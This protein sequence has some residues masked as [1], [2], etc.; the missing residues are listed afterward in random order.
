MAVL[1][2]ALFPGISRADGDPA[3]DV[4]ATQPLFLPQDAGLA[5][6]QQEQLADLLREA[7]HGGFQIRV[8]LIASPAD[9]GSIPEL[10][11]QPA[12]YARYL[13]QE[14]ELV[15][16]GP[17][18]VVMPNGYSVY[19]A[20]GARP[21]ERAAIAELPA[22][23]AALGLAA[24]GAVRRIAAADGH[25]L[26]LPNASV[27]ASP[28]SENAIAWLVVTVG[29]AL[30]ALAWTLSLRARPVRRTRTGDSPG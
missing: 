30:I 25:S 14:L 20:G 22:P 18:L 11:R 7:S 10:W 13:G 2:C 26:T 19:R 12:T 17:L 28:G 8:A 21:A 15:Y 9:L 4:L 16:S 27:A 1:G 29:A 24:I 5:L 6:R 3:S 23:G